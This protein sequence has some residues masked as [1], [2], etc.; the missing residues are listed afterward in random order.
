MRAARTS[1]A[2]VQLQGVG[3]RYGQV[4]AV[5]PLDLSIE[6]GTLVTLLGPSGCGKTTLLRMIAGLE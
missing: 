2:G 6:D 4:Q 3:K 5:K 1:V